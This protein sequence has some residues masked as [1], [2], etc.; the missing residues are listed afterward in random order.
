MWYMYK[1]CFRFKSNHS[2]IYHR[3]SY[4]RY[5]HKNDSTEHFNKQNLRRILKMCKFKPPFESNY[6][7]IGNTQLKFSNKLLWTAYMQK[8]CK[9][10][11]ERAFLC[12][13]RDKMRKLSYIWRSITTKIENRDEGHILKF[14][15][16][17][18]LERRILKTSLPNIFWVAK[19][20]SN[21]ATHPPT[22]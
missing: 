1:Y 20:V 18:W 16:H 8:S 15:T 11:C 5:H 9:G 13:K 12:I 7:N 14:D 3:K 6:R 2:A 21:E 17:D 22:W 10:Y 4:C 19:R